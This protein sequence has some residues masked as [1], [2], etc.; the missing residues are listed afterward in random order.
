MQGE[1]QVSAGLFRVILSVPTTTYRD[2]PG[3]RE[4]FGIKKPGNKGQKGPSIYLYLLTYLKYIYTQ[5]ATVFVIHP[6]EHN[7]LQFSY[8]D[9]VPR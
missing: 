4:N 9:V 2:R 1:R 3:G 7:T 6:P 8:G 5:G